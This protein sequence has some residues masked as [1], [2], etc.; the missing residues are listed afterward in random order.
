MCVASNRKIRL[1]CLAIF[2]FLSARSQTDFTAQLSNW[3]TLFPKEDVIAASYKET[4]TF[5]LNDKPGAG[6]GNVNAKVVNELTIVPVK[7]F[8]KY[9]DGLYYNDE[10]SIDNVKAINSKGKEINVQKLCGSY[11]DED[12]F[13]SD[14]KVCA[15]TFSLEEKGK[16][17]VYPKNGCCNQ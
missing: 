2:L 8:M 11:K 9:Q 15:I 4:V 7:D 13:H 6:E 14:S 17:F 12:I 3:K 1:T 10:L 5:A 16:G